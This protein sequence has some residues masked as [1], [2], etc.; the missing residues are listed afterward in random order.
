MTANI[1]VRS[2]RIASAIAASALGVAA[3]SPAGALANPAFRAP[4]ASHARP[5]AHRSAASAQNAYTIL[6]AFAGP[7]GAFAVGALDEA[8]AYSN[9]KFSTSAYGVTQTGGANNVGVVYNEQLQT[10]A[11]HVI[12]SFAAPEGANPAAGLDNNAS[13][14][15]AAGSPQ[16]GTTQ[17]GGASGNGTLYIITASGAVTVAHSFTGGADGANPTS[18]ITAFTDGNYYGTTQNGG[19]KGF[20]TIFKYAPK[21]RAFTTIH[22]FTG[23]ADGGNPAAGLSIRIVRSSSASAPARK[24]TQPEFTKLANSTVSVDKVLYGVTTVGGNGGG[25]TIYSVAPSGTFNTLYNF[26][27]GADGSA[28]VA[29]LTPDANG[30]LY[31]TASNGGSAGVGTVFV[32]APGNKFSVIQDFYVDANGNEPAGATPLAPI[33][34]AFNGALYGTASAGGANG[35]GEVFKIAGGTFTDIHDFTGADGSS[36]QGKLLDG[37]DGNLYGTTFFGGPN[38]D[39]V[40]FKIAQ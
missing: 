18:R 11:F 16:I 6:H 17:N 14:Y 33:T 21:T 8:I 39:G 31:G 13:D 26:T 38:G 27:N 25:G 40:L 20:G 30:N 35:F 34:V 28:P 2:A 4:Y 3:I 19:T 15:L 24:L 1:T 37:L 7:D 36:P 5:V 32:L 23:G 10:G 22:E 12:H 9:G 29:E